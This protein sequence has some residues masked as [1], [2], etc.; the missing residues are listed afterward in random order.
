[1]D[2]LW[3]VLFKAMVCAGTAVL[4]DQE[5]FALTPLLEVQGFQLGFEHFCV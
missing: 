2:L 5:S 4:G 3:C 1:M